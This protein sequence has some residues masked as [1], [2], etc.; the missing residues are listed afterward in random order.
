MAV[1]QRRIRLTP[2]FTRYFVQGQHDCFRTRVVADGANGLPN[3]VFAWRQI[4]LQPAEETKTAVFSHVCSPVD[5]ADFPIDAPRVN[6]VPPWFRLD[7]VEYD[8]WTREEAY[9]TYQAIVADVASLLVSLDNAE[10]MVE[11][12]P[13][14][15]GYHPWD[16]SSSVGSDGGDE[17]D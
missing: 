7:W 10:V 17:E 5:L 6:D 12:P 13:I 4:P 2:S 16:D 15:L 14:W 11:E 3:R 1:S 8:T 9:E